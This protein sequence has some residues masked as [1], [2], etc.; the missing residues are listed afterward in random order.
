MRLTLK[1]TRIEIAGMM[2][3]KSIE[4]KFPTLTKLSG[5]YSH[6]PSNGFPDI[7]R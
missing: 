4:I 3:D 6:S 2:A 7:D 1:R 5:L